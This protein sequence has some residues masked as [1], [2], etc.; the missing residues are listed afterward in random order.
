MDEYYKK[1]KNRWITDARK[2]AL[3]IY[4]KTGRR[5]TIDEMSDGFYWLYSPH[6]ED[7]IK[8]RKEFFALSGDE[9]QEICDSFLN[10]NSI[11][12]SFDEFLRDCGI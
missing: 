12:S 1:R 10:S 2:V 8:F 7:S 4:S 5:P 6:V 3:E 11:Y 9:Y